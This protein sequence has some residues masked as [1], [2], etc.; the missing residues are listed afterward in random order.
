MAA[1]GSSFLS[2]GVASAVLAA[3]VPGVFDPA[4]PL[5]ATPVL[6]IEKLAVEKLPVAAPPA[7]A[8]PPA[9]SPARPAVET[10]PA[11]TRQPEPETIMSPFGRRIVVQRRRSSIPLGCER[12]VSPL[13]RSSA[14]ATIGRCIT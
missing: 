2:L 10:V 13:V 9:A 7:P 4:P 8:A 12:L 11:S 5:V 14:S 6:A 1:K 3:F